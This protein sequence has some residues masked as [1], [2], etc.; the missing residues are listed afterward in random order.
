MKALAFA[1]SA[2]NP[3]AL[4]NI[5]LVIVTIIYLIVLV[6]LFLHLRR[7]NQKM[8]DKMKQ[9]QAEKRAAEAAKAAEEEP[10]MSKLH[11][12]HPRTEEIHTDPKA[13]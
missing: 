4:R 3:H 12:A 6:V 5:L 9:L 11:T 1:F 10:L 2:E 8:A 13:S 7:A